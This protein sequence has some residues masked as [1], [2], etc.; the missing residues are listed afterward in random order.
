[1]LFATG[2]D[3]SKIKNLY[4]SDDEGVEISFKSIGA[5]LRHIIKIFI[6]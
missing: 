4:I 5:F 6:V 2:K 1:M 3:A